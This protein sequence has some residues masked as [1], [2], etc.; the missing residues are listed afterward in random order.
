MEQTRIWKDEV[1]KL[2]ER[3]DSTFWKPK[4]GQYQVKFFDEGVDGT[5]VWEGKT[6]STVN[7]GVEVKTLHAS[8]KVNTIEKLSWTVTRG[9]TKNSLFGQLS[10]VGKLYGKLSGNT[11]TVIVRGE[12]KETNYTVLEAVPL[13]SS[14]ETVSG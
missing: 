4:P 1:N 2:K 5:F 7:F 6:I 13:T 14:E 3:G 9:V 11:L 10:L 12:G 8:G